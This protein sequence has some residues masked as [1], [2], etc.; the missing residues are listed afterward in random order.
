MV[1]LDK[2]KAQREM[3]LRLGVRKEDIEERFVCSQGPGGQNVNKV[4]TCVYLK[5]IPTGIEVKCQV[6]RS[7]AQNRFLA[8]QI[9]LKKIESI[10][11]GKLS[12]E[13][14]RIEK[15]RRQKRRRSRRAKLKMLESKRL[16][17]V[18]KSFRSGVREIEVS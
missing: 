3:M 8:R 10:I 14:K 6:E 11:L 1:R 5:H 9:L 7:Q 4:S 12:Q 2:E 18:K 15:I 13:R 17:S 16:H